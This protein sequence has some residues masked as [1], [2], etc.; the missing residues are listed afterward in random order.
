MAVWGTQLIL[1]CVQFAQ[2]RH[3]AGQN[4]KKGALWGKQQAWMCLSVC[5]CVCDRL[6]V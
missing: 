1:W 2:R 5:E 3:P 6:G 4:R